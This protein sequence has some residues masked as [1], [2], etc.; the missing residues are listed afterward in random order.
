MTRKHFVV[1][2]AI[3]F[4]GAPAMA[5]NDPYTPFGLP[6][7][8]LLPVFIGLFTWLG[9]GHTV[10]GY[11]KEKEKEPQK[12]SILQAGCV[13]LVASPL[14]VVGLFLLPTALAGIAAIVAAVRVVK[15]IV[16]AVRA[17]KP[18]KRLERLASVRPKRMLL[19]A[20]GLAVTDVVVLGLMI[21]SM[22]GGDME[23][24]A[25]GAAEVL[26]KV[27][28]TQAQYHAI[29]GT[30]AGRLDDL[31]SGSDPLLNINSRLFRRLFARYSFNL[32]GDGNAYAVQASPKT[33]GLTSPWVPFF[34][35]DQ[36]GQIRAKRGAPADARS[37]ALEIFLQRSEWIRPFL[38]Y[39]M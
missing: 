11:R 33:Y 25:R 22:Q 37:D 24:D 6:A 15:M 20:A 21:A 29:H 18:E 31:T 38:G 3:L 5:N 28:E 7:A 35:M 30:Y 14:L 1:M 19:S 9:G 34:Y 2:L 4:A 26:R 13:L 27:F 16:W 23:R 39:V 17:W 8:I 36:T 10:L 12:H 32:S